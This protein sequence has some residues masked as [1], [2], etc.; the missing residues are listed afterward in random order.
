MAHVEQTAGVYPNLDG[1]WGAVI[2]VYG[3]RIILGEDFPS[4]EMAKAYFDWAKNMNY[5]EE[6]HKY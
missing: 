6:L 1:T 3:K 5:F 2:T 4:A